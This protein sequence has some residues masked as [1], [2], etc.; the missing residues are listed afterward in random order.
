M[1]AIRTIVFDVGWVLVHLDYA[2]LTEFLRAH[3]ADVTQRREIWSRIQLERHETGAMPGEELLAHLARLGTR[4]MNVDELRSRWTSMFEVQ[5]AMIELAQRLATRY[6]VHLLSNVGDLHWL[7][8]VREFRLDRL[9]HGALTSFEAG[10]MK[11]HPGIY[12]LAEKRFGL[13]PP[14]TVFIDDLAANVD[15]AR[16]RGWQGIE[17]KN[18]GETV[19]ALAALGVTA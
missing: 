6:R 8:L 15:G 11:P 2:P 13:E 17:H 18:Y 12:A 16:A 9:G 5:P 1:T 19:A 14:A 3:G 4:P 10:L 7:A